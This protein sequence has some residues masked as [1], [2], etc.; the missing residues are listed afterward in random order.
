MKV[1]SLLLL[2]LLLLQPSGIFSTD[3]PKQDLLGR[4]N[5]TNN[6]KIIQNVTIAQK[7]KLVLDADKNSEAKEERQL[8]DVLTN[9]NKDNLM[10]KKIKVNRISGQSS[11]KLNKS[12]SYGQRKSDTV[13]ETLNTPDRN[14]KDSNSAKTPT[15]R[16]LKRRKKKRQKKKSLTKKK[17]GKK[18]DFT[19][20]LKPPK[21]PKIPDFMGPYKP[22]RRKP[23]DFIDNLPT[24]I[25]PFQYKYI[26]GKKFLVRPVYNEGKIYYQTWMN[27]EKGYPDTDKFSVIDQGLSSMSPAL[28]Q[29]PNPMKLMFKKFRDNANT[30]KFTPDINAD[31]EYN[32]F[33]LNFPY[34]N[35]KVDRLKQIQ[36]NLIKWMHIDPK[37]ETITTKY[38]QQNGKTILNRVVV[39]YFNQQYYKK[40]NYIIN[41]KFSTEKINMNHIAKLSKKVGGPQVSAKYYERNYQFTKNFKCNVIRKKLHN[42]KIFACEEEINEQNYILPD[43]LLVSFVDKYTLLKKQDLLFSYIPFKKKMA[44]AVYPTQIWAKTE[45][46]AD[47]EQLILGRVNVLKRRYKTMIPLIKSTIKRGKFQRSMAKLM[48][49]LAKYKLYYRTHVSLGELQYQ[50]DL[51]IDLWDLQKQLY[52]RMEQVY[53]NYEGLLNKVDNINSYN[54]NQE[55]LKMRSRL[56]TLENFHTYYVKRRRFII[57]EHIRKIL[58]FLDYIIYLK[59]RK[60]EGAIFEPFHG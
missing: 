5:L 30:P 58:N 23:K 33:T 15:A 21:L 19:I 7:N 34:L 57:E 10:D 6:S 12:S 60:I 36:N 45:P 1:K 39:S 24:N 25:A 26:K 17:K 13:R 41:V 20:R 22:F 3:S 35:P 8:S 51:K 31:F 29:V 40:K 52:S 59:E 27:Q 54:I 43:I 28:S 37:S 53:R 48:A 46:L 9:V 55:I 14:L 47:P 11:S 50:K 16:N 4:T 42:P 38:F 49:D 18:Q 2:G 44:K 32:Y 56:D